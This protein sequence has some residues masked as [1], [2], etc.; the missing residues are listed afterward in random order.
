MRQRHHSEPPLPGRARQKLVPQFPRRHLD[1][2]P[3]LAGKGA[4]L[5]GLDDAF[6]P[7]P[8]GRPLDEL[9]VPP[10]AGPAQTMVKV[11]HHQ[12]PAPGR[13][14]RVQGMQQHHGIHPARDRHQHPLPRRD[15]TPPPD[16][17]FD[18]GEQ[19]MHAVRL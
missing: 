7:Q 19:G 8:P 13:S 3:A 4:H 16:G 1:G 6:Q 18:T 11:R 5:T 17:G 10:A 12:P 14:Q 9:R 2:P 15:Q